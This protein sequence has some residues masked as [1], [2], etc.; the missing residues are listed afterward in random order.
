VQVFHLA[1]ISFVI[2]PGFAPWTVSQPTR[3][4]T[5]RCRDQRSTQLNLG[6]RSHCVICVN[7][8]LIT[9]RTVVI[10][11]MPVMTPNLSVSRCHG[12][13]RSC[14]SSDSV[15]VVLVVRMRDVC[16]QAMC[17]LLFTNS[18]KKTAVKS[19]VRAIDCRH[20][21]FHQHFLTHHSTKLL[22][23]QLRL[24]PFRAV[25]VGVGS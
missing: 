9:H 16:E 15:V 3:D 20:S 17:R 8:P 2:N 5:S 12:D 4:D 11:R 10:C 14:S 6:G 13:R 22:W 18:N 7:C 25:F 1:F 21:D 24:I 19:R 23:A